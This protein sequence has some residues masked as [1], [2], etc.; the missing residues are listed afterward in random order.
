MK[1]ICNTLYKHLLDPSLEEQVLYLTNEQCDACAEGI[2]LSDVEGMIMQPFY[3]NKEFLD[4]MPNLK[5]V[6]ITGAGYDRVDIEEVKKRGLVLTNTRGV[7]SISIAED[8]FSKMLFLSRKMRTIEADKKAHVWEMFGQDQ[9]MC[10]CY[11]DLYGK[12]IG[13]M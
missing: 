11:A 4:R 12:T 3:V 5:W 7:M 10:T 2:D 1:F 9:W 13:I 6:Q 8:I